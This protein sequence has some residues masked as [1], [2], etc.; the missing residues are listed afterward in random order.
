LAAIAEAETK[1]QELRQE[2]SQLEAYIAPIGCEAHKYD[3]RRGTRRF[4]YN[5]LT[6]RVAIFAPAAKEE[7]VKVI[8][9]SHDDDPRNFEGRRGIE[10][11][12]ALLQAKT[13]LNTAVAAL[14]SAVELV[15]VL[16]NRGDE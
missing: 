9:L 8:H 11:R 14:E 16:A 13:Q 3:V 6:A 2:L 7:Q 1:I 15:R 10:R 4:W 12:N 5:K